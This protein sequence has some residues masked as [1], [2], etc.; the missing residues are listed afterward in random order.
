MTRRFDDLSWLTARPIAHRG[1]HDM[2][3]TVWENTVSAALRAVE[4]GFAIECDVHLAADSVPVVFHDDDLQRLCGLPG[5]VR[6]NT[7]AELALKSVGGT[8]DTVPPLPT[9]LKAIGGRVP[10]VIE[11]KGRDG[12]DDGFVDAVLEYLEGYNGHVALMSFD[13]W[14]LQDLAEARPPCPIGLTAEGVKPEALAA[15]EEAMALGL[16]FISYCVHHLPNPFVTAQRA[17]GV[18]VITWTVRDPATRAHSDAHADQ[19]TFEG[20]DPEAT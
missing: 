18:P 12:E 20:F 19:I 7:C 9:F 11:L 3:R 14:L 13:R 1:Y 6:L 8:K 15:H 16:D 17:R 10:L 4:R 5:D 2:N